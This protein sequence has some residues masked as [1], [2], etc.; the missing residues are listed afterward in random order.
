MVVASGNWVSFTADL[1]VT[2]AVLVVE[3]CQIKVGQG[4][5]RATVTGAFQTE[6]QEALGRNLVG[7]RA[8]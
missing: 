5:Q 7:N 4:H 1:A 3:A 6:V 2:S 8:C